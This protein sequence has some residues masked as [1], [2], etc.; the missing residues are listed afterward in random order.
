MMG[1]AVDDALSV[2]GPNTTDNSQGVAVAFALMGVCGLAY[3]IT[4][5]NAVRRTFATSRLRVATELELL[6]SVARAQRRRTAVFAAFSALA[7]FAIGSL[8]IDLDTRI[9]LGV[10]PALLMTIAIVTLCRLQMLLG[11]RAEPAL[12]VSAHGDFLFVARG[13]R[14]VGWVAAPPKL[15]A[16]ASGLPVATLRH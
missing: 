8:P 3:A 1:R 10:T 6:K 5:A 2:L 14:L 11:L 13:K 16:R 7:A 4:R 12:R 9:V 15:V